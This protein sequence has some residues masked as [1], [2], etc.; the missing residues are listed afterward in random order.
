MSSNYREV[1]R[2]GTI[3]EPVEVG[4]VGRLGSEKKRAGCFHV[5]AGLILK[6]A[7]EAGFA[8]TFV[9]FSW[10]QRKKGRAKISTLNGG[11]TTGTTMEVFL[12]PYGLSGGQPGV[13][14]SSLCPQAVDGDG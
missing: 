13:I 2:Q 7:E 1:G 5:R 11:M 9:H 8:F 3:P 6:S 14:Q 4:N 10:L 12:D